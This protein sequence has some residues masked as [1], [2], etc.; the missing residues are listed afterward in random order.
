MSRTLFENSKVALAFAAITV[1]GAVSMVGTSDEGGV[2]TAVVERFGTN[3]E[4][5]ASAEQVSSQT[6]RDDGKPAGAGWGSASPTSVFGEFT[7]SP[8]AGEAAGDSA[9]DSAGPIGNPMT[10]PLSPTAVVTQGPSGGFFSSSSD[11]P[12]PA[13]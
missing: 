2:L 11:E 1:I 3:P 5:Q 13:E 6:P 8:S 10:A 12:P 9:G 4:G 7:G